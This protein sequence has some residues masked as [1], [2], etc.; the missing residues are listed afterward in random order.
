MSCETIVPTS[1]F[2]K[3]FYHRKKFSPEISH[4]AS[5]VFESMRKI[6]IVLSRWNNLK[7]FVCIQFEI[8]SFWVWKQNYFLF[9]FVFL[10]FFW[11]AKRLFCRKTEFASPKINNE[12]LPKIIDYFAIYQNRSKFDSICWDTFRPEITRNNI[13]TQQ[14]VTKIQLSFHQDPENPNFDIKCILQK[15]LIFRL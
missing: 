9:N 3:K 7:P 15:E 2:S 13:L 8:L 14:F 5:N 6:L 12:N 1:K 4:Q 10:T 11:G